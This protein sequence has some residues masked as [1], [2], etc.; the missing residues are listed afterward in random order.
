MLVQ[1]P[2]VSNVAT[3]TPGVPSLDFEQELLSLARQHAEEAEVYSVNGEETPV[4]F[5]ANLVEGRISP[6]ELRGGA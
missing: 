4:A 1:S 2:S 6:P 5:E 3:P